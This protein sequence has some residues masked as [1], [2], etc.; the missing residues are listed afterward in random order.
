MKGRKINPAE[1]CKVFD[2]S[3]Y[4][5]SEQYK[6]NIEALKAIRDKAQE[7]HRSIR[8]YTVAHLNARIKVFKSIVKTIN[9]P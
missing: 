2:C 7:E 8:G 6:R 5:L 3:P 4:Q 9:K 1:L